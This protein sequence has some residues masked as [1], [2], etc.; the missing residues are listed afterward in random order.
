MKKV[1]LLA[2]FYPPCGGAGVQRTVKFVKCLPDLGYLPV[3]IA[4]TGMDFGFPDDH[5]L[6]EE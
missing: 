3:V 1:L 6:A 5:E 2:Y 4:G